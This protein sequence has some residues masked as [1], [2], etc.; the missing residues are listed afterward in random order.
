MNMRDFFDSL[1]THFTDTG[2]EFVVIG[3]FALHAFGS[4]RMTK[5]ADFLVRERNQGDIA[6]FL[7]SLGFERVHAS[8]GFS[9]HIHPLGWR[10]DFVYV[11]D[12]T[13]DS[14]FSDSREM[15]VFNDLALPVPSAEHLLALKLFAADNDPD[16]KLQDL[17]DARTVI[18]NAAIP[19]QT[20]RELCTRYHMEDH[21][22]DLTH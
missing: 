21:F 17:A 2:I 16:R 10:V 4:T 14:I 22:N 19:T 12:G 15:F 13:A 6:A 5:D 1:C 20:V 3:G 7:D 8:S 18:K 9:N 11:N